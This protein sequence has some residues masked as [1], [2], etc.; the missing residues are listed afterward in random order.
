MSTMNRENELGGAGAR[1]LATSSHLIHLSALDLSGTNIG[2]DGAR[3]V[4]N[5]AKLKLAY[6]DL[7][8]NRLGVEGAKALAASEDFR[9]IC[10]T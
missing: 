7:G 3:A 6:L 8:W 1:A 2:A 4:A 5:A 9:G 10:G